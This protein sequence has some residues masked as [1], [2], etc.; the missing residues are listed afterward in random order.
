MKIYYKSEKH[1]IFCSD[2]TVRCI[3]GTDAGLVIVFDSSVDSQLVQ[4]TIPMSI[5]DA[6][7]VIGMIPYAFKKAADAIGGAAS[8]G[9]I[10][11]I[12]IDEIYSWID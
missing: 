8:E 12:D 5:E 11:F 3:T 9:C 10:L 1:G 4:F 6:R 7:K 2:E